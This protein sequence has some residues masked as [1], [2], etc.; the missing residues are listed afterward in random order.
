MNFKKSAVAL[1]ILTSILVGCGSINNQSENQ[2]IEAQSS[3]ITSTAQSTQGKII[4]ISKDSP[5]YGWDDALAELAHKYPAFGGYYYD[6]DTLVILTATSYLGKAINDT[7]TSEKGRKLG[8]IKSELLDLL[9]SPIAPV[10]LDENGNKKNIN[11]VKFSKVK[12]SYADLQNWR[13]NL[14]S[15]LG[16]GVTEIGINKQENKVDVG[17]SEIVNGISGQSLD[18]NQKNATSSKISAL[19][20]PD[21]AINLSHIE[22]SSTKTLSDLFRPPVGGIMWSKKMFKADGTAYFPD[23]CTIGLNVDYG[24]KRGFITASHCTDKLGNDPSPMYAYNGKNADGV[25]Y[26]IGQEYYDPPSGSLVNCLWQGTLTQPCR[27]ADVA[28]FQYSITADRGKIAKTTEKRGDTTTVQVNGVDV[29]YS[30]TSVITRP[31][32]GVV[33]DNVGRV[34]GWKQAVVLGSSTDQYIGKDGLGYQLLNSVKVRSNTGDTNTSIATCGGDSGGPWYQKK[35][36]GTL[37][38]AGIQSGGGT[39]E[40]V[41]H[42]DNCYPIAYFTPVDNMNKSF[43]DGLVFTK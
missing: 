20:I 24:G 37:A 41:P 38:F 39:I 11:K 27:L 6:E 17:Y 30:V 12:Y 18:S 19:G 28:F 40:N 5:L 25:G 23:W 16:S 33:L 22:T 4:T 32:V 9:N 34:G 35:Q 14:R 26:N 42:P 36:D 1:S 7:D 15:L 29:S 2:T 3:N 10:L 13:L 21:D 8:V 43:P 31:E